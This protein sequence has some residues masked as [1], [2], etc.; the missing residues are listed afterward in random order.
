MNRRNVKVEKIF[1]TELKE[2]YANEITNKNRILNEKS[3]HIGFADFI[4]QFI[5]TE[6]K[7]YDQQLY[8]NVYHKNG[9]TYPSPKTI[10]RAFIKDEEASINLLNICG[11]F[12]FQ[13]AWEN[14]MARFDFSSEIIK[15]N[16]NFHTS[17]FTNMEAGG[18]I[19][20][21]IKNS[22]ARIANVKAVK[23]ININIE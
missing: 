9:R 11:W 4:N 22:T 6:L 7:K 19:D 17:S 8:Y 10:Y 1:I 13:E 12:M 15:E 18:E 23:D 20:I 16:N 21:K 5:Q 14:E 2:R 3:W